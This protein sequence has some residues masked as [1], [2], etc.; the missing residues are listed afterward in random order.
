MP[1]RGVDI[2]T[3]RCKAPFVK[4]LQGGGLGE[5]SIAFRRRW[6]FKMAV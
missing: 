3:G 4:L 2:F 1:A 5:L 6:V